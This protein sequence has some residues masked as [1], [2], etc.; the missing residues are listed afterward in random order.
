MI[1]NPYEKVSFEEFLPELQL[2]IP[3]LPNDIL[4]HYVRNASIEFAKRTGILIRHIE[5]LLEPCVENYLLE[6]VDCLTIN[7]VI[8]VCR[9]GHSVV[10]VPTA[11]CAKVNC[12]GGM[13]MWWEEP[14][15]AYFTPPPAKECLVTVTVSV[16]PSDDACEVDK[17]LLTTHRDA[18]L[19]G[20][21]SQLYAIPR[22]DWSDGSMATRSLSMFETAIR[23]TNTRRVLGN[24]SGFFRNGFSTRFNR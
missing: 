20:A 12:G 6:T 17:V 13:V 3:E 24:Q 10:R 9:D 16:T 5:L 11:K 1:I 22:R 2:E 21:R 7:K 19:H 18:I 14:N 4:M 23:K 15:I 8:N